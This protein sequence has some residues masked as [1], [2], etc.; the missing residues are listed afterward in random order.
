MESRAPSAEC[1]VVCVGPSPGSERLVGATQRLAEAAGARW[2]AVH[3]SLTGAAPLSAADRDRVEG[4]LFLAESL[5]AEIAYLVGRSIPDKVLAFAR[6]RTATRIV[7]GKPTHPRWRDRLRR[8]W[9]HTL[10][11]DS[12]DLE[13]LIIAPA[14][15]G[16]RR[17]P[18]T[19][20]APRIR[21]WLP[22]LVAVAAATA[23]GVLADARFSLP[24]QAMLYLAAIMVAAL[25][26][27][28]TGVLAAALSVAAYNFFFI[29]PRYTFNV[30]DLDHLLTF[31]LMFTVGA[32]MGTLVA[33][34]RH[35]EAAARQRERRTSALLGLTSQT[36][37]AENIADVAAAVVAQ[38]EDALRCPAVVLVPGVGA[39]LEAV[40]GLEPLAPQ[41][42]AVARWAHEHR[43]TAGRG[44]E[45]APAARLLAVPL[46]AGHDSAGVVAVQLERARRRMDLE[47]RELLEAIA[48]QAGIAIA[49][50]RLER[51]ATEA[52]LRVHAEELRSSLL[53]TV[54]HDLRTPLAAIT[55]MATALRDGA[56]LTRDQRDALD[57]ITGEAARLG[58][59]LHNL[60]AI[61][62]VESG[63]E[64]RRD[65]V[66]LEEV[67][68]GALG[69]LEARLASHRVELEVDPEACA[70]VDAILFE[71]LLLNLL[72]NAA[73]HTAPGTLIEIAGC[74][75]GADVVL[76]VADRGPG[77]PPGP[78]ERLFEKFY[79][80][81]GVRGA[82]AGLGLAVCRGITTAHGGTIEAENRTGGGATFRVRVP[83]GRLSALNDHVDDRVAAS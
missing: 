61:T 57:M 9:L 44:T 5:G 46:W 67:I 10:I 39:D 13:I 19:R 31:A 55:G 43:R 75:D 25:D 6:A 22:G 48:R 83:G 34:L 30:A 66:P 26:G 80:G 15:S 11:R 69:R 45:M 8:S 77:L 14:D 35:S 64:L 1:F 36:A 59:I 28:T 51:E 53:S 49:R 73:K 70:Y 32:A 24:D 20:A 54:S 16:P 38:V 78:T 7:A 37:A 60:L 4:H 3:V 63:A 62:R 40:A 58:A 12:G 18:A 50:L 2:Y 82:G 27:R 23:S 17:R 71:Q 76:E 79:R 74:G 47:A 33:R 65:W 29:P 42:L 72:E 56:N 68:G 41:E 21:A 81:P 52:A